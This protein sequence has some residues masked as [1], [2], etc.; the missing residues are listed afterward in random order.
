MAIT[1]GSRLCPGFREVKPGLMA[2]PP[3]PRPGTRRALLASAMSFQHGREELRTPA[4]TITRD[5]STSSIAEDRARQDTR[6]QA[7]TPKSAQQLPQQA[8][9]EVS[10]D[11]INPLFWDHHQTVQFLEAMKIDEGGMM[12]ARR[13]FGGG[14]CTSRLAECLLAG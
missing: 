14:S 4:G 7:R 12:F 11:S 9:A 6:Q 8:T 2:T 10:Y 3:P 5:S 13:F 1:D